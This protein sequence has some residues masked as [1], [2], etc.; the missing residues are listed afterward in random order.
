MITMLVDLWLCV[1]IALVFAIACFHPSLTR[2]H[3]F[4]CCLLGLGIPLLFYG[5]ALS[6]YASMTF[7]PFLD[8]LAF[9]QNNWLATVLLGMLTVVLIAG[10]LSVLLKKRTAWLFYAGSGLLLIVWGIALGAQMALNPNP[11][12]VLDAALELLLFIVYSMVLCNFLLNDGQSKASRFLFRYLWMLFPAAAVV[13]KLFGLYTVSA[14][15]SFVWYWLLPLFIV[16]GFYHLIR[17]LR[18]RKK[19]AAPCV[20]D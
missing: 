10:I 16:Y 8:F 14:F 3:R 1:L 7:S 19:G 4:L 17:W 2:F 13:Y 9:C 6:E 15:V 18:A 11:P 12:Q 5:P 20:Q